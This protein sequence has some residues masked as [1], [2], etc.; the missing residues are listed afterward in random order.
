[1]NLA[2]VRRRWAELGPRPRLLVSSAGP[3]ALYLILTQLP[4]SGSYIGDRAPA[5]I[6]VQGVVF[7]T[8][9]GLGALGL[10]LVYRA[11][12]FINF[13]HGALGSLVGVL[14]IGLVRGDGF[15]FTPRFPFLF[16][17]Y[18][19]FHLHIHHL[20]YWLAL[21]LGVTVG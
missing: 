2:E 5:G 4:G 6:I 9:T 11:N 17:G 12:R 1:M 13:A 16:R 8:L 20:N 10:V 14:A 21:G 18:T 15:V 19:L 3:V 7:G